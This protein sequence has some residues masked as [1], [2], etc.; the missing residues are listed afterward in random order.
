MIYKKNSR[1][2]FDL[3][4]TVLSCLLGA[5]RTSVA[6]VST[7]GAMARRI[8]PVQLFIVLSGVSILSVGWCVLKENEL[9]NDVGHCF[10]SVKV[11]KTQWRKYGGGGGG[12]WGAMTPH[13]QRGP[14]L[15]PVCV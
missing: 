11:R 12:G 1:I 10:Y 5:R 3:R 14:P 7:L 8:D 9:V 2:R 15:A 6:G 4:K 13:S